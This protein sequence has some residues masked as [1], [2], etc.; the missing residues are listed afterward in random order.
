MDTNPINSNM[1]K[2]SI[3]KKIDRGVLFG[4]KQVIDIAKKNKTRI[5]VSDADKNIIKL[6]I[7][8]AMAN[9]NKALKDMEAGNKT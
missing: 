4:S 2:I 3:F 8:Q 7:P 6:S 1:S 9:Y 5:V